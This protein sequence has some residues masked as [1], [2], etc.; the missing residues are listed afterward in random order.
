M[1][2]SR[3]T[4]A[5]PFFSDHFVTGSWDGGQWALHVGAA[6]LCLVVLG[7]LIPVLVGWLRDA[8]DQTETWVR[9]L[10]GVVTVALL[11]SAMW[12]FGD[13]IFEILNH[14]P[15]TSFREKLWKVALVV[16]I[17]AAAQTG[18][19]WCI[20]ARL[21]DGYASPRADLIP[22]GLGVAAPV[23]VGVW[24][25]FATIPVVFGVTVFGLFVFA[26]IAAALMLANNR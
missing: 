16:L 18:A 1:M 25:L 15:A 3:S 22:L 11:V 24:V 23:I 21:F 12:V 7:A 14:L 6:L 8:W 20:W 19:L 17:A 5:P 2:L 4:D 10:G 13:Q 9:V 26:V